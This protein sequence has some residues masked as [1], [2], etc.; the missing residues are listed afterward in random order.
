[1]VAE[2]PVSEDDEGHTQRLL[3]DLVGNPPMGSSAESI[4]RA[5]GDLLAKIE[6]PSGENSSYWRLRLFSGTL[7]T[8]A[9]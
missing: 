4:I 8:P 9:G 7:L 2:S 3:K 5:V 6:K 1:M